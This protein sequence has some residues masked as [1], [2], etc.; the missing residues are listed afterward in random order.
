MLI[1]AINFILIAASFLWA[2]FSLKN[3]PK[4][5]LDIEE[6]K[7]D[8]VVYR[9]HAFCVD[10]EIKNSGEPA[11][12]FW[13]PYK[14]LQ[15]GSYTAKIEYSADSDQE[16]LADAYR[17]ESVHVEASPGF[18]SAYQH[19]I[20]Y[21]FE[22]KKDV[23]N[24]E[25]RI[26]YSGYGDF[27]IRS[28]SIVPNNTRIKRTM[29]EIIAGVLLIDCAVVFAGLS[30]ER[31]QTVLMLAGIGILASLPLGVRGIYDGHDLDVHLMRIE[32]VAQALRSEQFP[33]RISSILVYGRGYPF[34]IFYNDI[35]LYFPA[36]LRL[37]GFSLTSA[38]KIFIF[39]MNQAGTVAAYL[40]FKPILKNKKNT[41]LLTLIYTTASY[42]LTNTYV[43]AAVGELT[44][45]V[46]LPLFGL[47]VYK[48]FFT[49][50][51]SFRDVLVNSLLL[52]G[53]V[54]GAVASH[55]PTPAMICF[56]M[57]LICIICWRK[58]LRKQTILTL[59]MA[60]GM[61]VLLNI[62]FLVPFADYYITEP[63]SIKKDAG[64]A[65]LRM[66]NRGAYPAELFS[67]FQSVDGMADEE[68]AERLQV[69]PGLPLIFVLFAGIWAWPGRLKNKWF[70][71]TM[72][73]SILTLLLS[74]SVFPW[75]FL[76]DRFWFWRTFTQMVQ[77]PW[78]FL[79]FSILFLTLAAGELLNDR[80]FSSS[81]HLLAAAAVV[82]VFWFMGSLFENCPVVD[83]YDSSS[84]DL[85]NVGLQGQY[86][87]QGSDR[88]ADTT[89]VRTQNMESAEILSR[90][91]DKTVLL[92]RSGINA[93]VHSVTVP[94]YNYKG[95]RVRDEAGNAYEIRNAEQNLISF[96][97]P[98]GFDG[99]V[100]VAF[101]DP[102][103]WTASLLI[104]A[105]SAAAVCLWIRAD[106][107][108][109]NTNV[110]EFRQT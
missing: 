37:F 101:R 51:G 18:L 76:A 35:F 60:A 69:S 24:F 82:M 72:G 102:V 42:R 70:G 52:A 12:I 80:S 88:Y 87:L 68:L 1:F 79:E 41:L 91:S 4:A 89:A 44:A 32:A 107:R 50:T 61:A 67:V 2:L 55:I 27:S 94:L 78:R 71:F 109:R 39:F 36:M 81:H 26:Q 84:L 57:L 48:I 20:S 47:S 62:Y 110:S 33:A 100:T 96:E 104:S 19:T 5:D 45:Q 56:L 6:W 75:D 58:T 93:G 97:L 66:Q 43:R 14:G 28:V 108:R 16:C 15:A 9:D 73:F 53:A 17:R 34:S 40:C 65:L 31:K 74:T 103:Y 29:A 8:H 90:S 64:E 13:G 105:I 85:N 23:D 46:F 49:E 54:S 25:L 99:T 10:D 98:D 3:L 38:Y 63:M 11:D 95:Y 86:F 21:P 106:F 22:V 77:F 83:P 7:M 59:A 30:A 92:C